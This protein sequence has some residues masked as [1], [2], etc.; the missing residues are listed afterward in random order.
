M[1]V[2]LVP[3]YCYY[4]NTIKLG[5]MP[6]F[7]LFLKTSL[8]L[9]TPSLRVK[10]APEVGIPVGR[11]LGGRLATTLV[12][13]IND[14]F[15][16]FPSSGRSARIKK[17]IWQTLKRAPINLRVGTFPDPVGH[18]GFC[19]WWG[20]PGATSLVLNFEL[21]GLPKWIGL[22]NNRSRGKL[23]TSSSLW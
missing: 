12:A 1:V 23:Q 15:F 13:T 5:K 8:K 11:H 16:L 18:F 4:S 9:L 22:G 3:K 6:L 2:S 19:M 10:L 21:D 20:A 14:I 7:L 17:L